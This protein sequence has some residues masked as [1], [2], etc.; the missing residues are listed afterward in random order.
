MIADLCKSLWVHESSLSIDQRTRL[1]GETQGRL[2]LVADGIGVRDGERASQLA[3]ESLVDYILNSLGWYLMSADYDA[4]DFQDALKMGLRHC[5]RMIEH[6]VAV[7]DDREAMKS[8]LTL[9]YIAW[10]QMFVVH[11]GNGRCHLIRDGVI[12]QMT[13]DHGLVDTILPMPHAEESSDTDSP[14]LL[15]NVISGEDDPH[16]DASSIEL[17]IGDVIVLCTDGLSRHVAPLQIRDQLCSDQSLEQGC[18]RLIADANVAGGTDN[19]TLVAYR[20][21]ET[22]EVEGDQAKVEQSST[23]RPAV[24]A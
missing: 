17:Q 3:L 9:A 16:P 5:Q 13:R 18:S 24:K 19:I 8:T 21:D 11:V 7:V 10:P 22:N 12:R 2:L 14:K 20:F 4:S 23:T 6:E 1:F 15:W